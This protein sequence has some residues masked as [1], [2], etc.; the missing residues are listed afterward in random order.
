[1]CAGIDVLRTTPRDLRFD[2]FHDALRDR[3]CLLV[4]LAAGTNRLAVDGSPGAVLAEQGV[5]R[6]FV[7]GKGADELTDAGELFR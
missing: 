4:G 3:L 2:G 1:M 5:I 6:R 7:P